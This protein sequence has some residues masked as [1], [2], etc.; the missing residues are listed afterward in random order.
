MSVGAM[1]AGGVRAP[2]AGVDGCHCLT[3]VL[4]LNLDLLKE[5]QVPNTKASLQ[6]LTL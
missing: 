3:R 4:E 1:E 6:P 5:Q 2:R